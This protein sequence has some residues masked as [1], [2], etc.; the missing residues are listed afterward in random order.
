VM[1]IRSN[2]PP[3]GF[4]LVEL[5]VGVA[6]VVILLA[7]AAPAMTQLVAQKRLK[8]V[9]AELITSLQYART[10]AVARNSSI[11]VMFESSPSMT[12]YIV[13]V[14]TNVSNCH[15]TGIPGSACVA[16]TATELHTTQIPVSTDVQV[17]NSTLGVLGIT[18]DGLLSP[19]GAS[20]V[21]T[22]SRVSGA[23]GTLKTTVNALGRPTV[24]S[25]DHSVPGV[26]AC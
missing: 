4:T 24:C 2:P 6:V 8:S 14:P 20:Y 3:R 25:P 12:C 1:R 21:V 11:K 13:F 18:S 26:P 19:A 9:N 7:I 17:L 5:M 10:E 22:T 16:G 15:C 23:S